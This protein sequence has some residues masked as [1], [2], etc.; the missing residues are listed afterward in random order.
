[1]AASQGRLCAAKG[2]NPMSKYANFDLQEFLR[3][4]TAKARGIDNTP[5]FE[6]VEHLDELI[7][8]ILQPLRTAWG[9]PLIISSGYRCEALNKAVGGV[10]N[11]AHVRGYAADV[12]VT[13]SK[14]FAPF[15]A[16]AEDWLRRNGIAFD[17]SIKE[18]SKTAY[19][20]HIGLYN[21]KG[22]Q[23][24]QFKALQV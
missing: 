2:Q 1:M 7:R 18:T 5:S 24:R 3:S 8:T 21:S 14:D 10:K 13:R 20:W 4:D 16:F 6:V 22:E 9:K 17:Q 11:S 12:Q 19:W 15:V 23:R